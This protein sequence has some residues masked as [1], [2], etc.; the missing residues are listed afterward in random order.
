MQTVISEIALTFVDDIVAAVTDFGQTIRRFT[1]D[2]L[3]A[4][5]AWVLAPVDR[6]AR[7]CDVGNVLPAPDV[8]APRE[9]RFAAWNV[10]EMFRT[11]HHL[12]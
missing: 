7:A 8:R 12:S 1:R 5:R 9:P 11:L 6:L 2:R 4:A 3:T 10:F